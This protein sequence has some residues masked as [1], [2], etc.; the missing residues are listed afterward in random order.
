MVDFPRPGHKCILKNNL[1]GGVVNE[2]IFVLIEGD[3]FVSDVTS[4]SYT[5]IITV[6]NNKIYE[7]GTEVTLQ[8]YNHTQ[9]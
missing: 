3:G 5:S 9:F 4:K 6:F 1:Y 8:Q 7:R 2:P